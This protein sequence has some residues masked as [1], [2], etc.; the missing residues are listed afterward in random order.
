[1]VMG[2]RFI[3]SESEM[4]EMESKMKEME[5]TVESGKKKI[6]EE[7]AVALSKMQT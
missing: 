1:M 6:E 5:A 4:S 3:I 7:T 2:K